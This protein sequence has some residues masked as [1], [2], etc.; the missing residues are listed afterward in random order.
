VARNERAVAFI[1]V[2]AL[3]LRS[4]GAWWR[5]PWHDEYFTAWAATLPFDRLIDALR[6]DS[7]PPLLYLMAR[8]LAVAG[9]PELAAARTVAV[10]AGTLAVVVAARAAGRAWG[11]AAAPGCA[12]LLAVHPVALAG[13]SGGRAYS[14]MLLAATLGWERLETLAATG[15]GAVGLG[16]AVALA[17]WSH[18]LG[19]IL[20][21]ALCLAA[22]LQP[23]ATRPRALLA[24]AAGLA[25]ILPWLPV[26]A[27]QPPAATV[28]MAASR[29][30]LPPAERLLAPIRLLPPAAPFDRALD[31]PGVAPAAALAAALACLILLVVVRPRPLPAALVGVPVVA[32]TVLPWLGV[33]V[34]YPGRAEAL[35]L[36]ALSG[37]VAAGAASWRPGRIVA[38][39][40]VAAGLAVWMGALVSWARKGPRPEARLAA[41][42]ASR[43]PEGGTVVLGGYWRLGLAFHLG[44]AAERYELINV[45][46]AA[47]RHRWYDPATDRPAPGEATGCCAVCTTGRRSR[48]SWCRVWL[49]EATCDDLAAALW[50]RPVLAV[51]AAERCAGGEWTRAVTTE[52]DGAGRLNPAG[53]VR[54]RGCRRPHGRGRRSSSRAGSARSVRALAFSAARHR[55]ARAPRRCGSAA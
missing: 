7:G 38:A 42:I 25:T 50:L 51:P 35:V 1:A 20:A 12:A 30:A 13:S 16:L 36:G 9:L 32:L 19:L 37:M 3:A 18:G 41:T 49:T 11:E 24:V 8:V 55:P 34:L 5:P 27:R 45:P 17:C 2:I 33:E 47:A 6:V 14:V 40:L 28:W 46:A 31:L 15:R 53:R 52:T 44:A 10:V 26:A 29:Q 22:L 23:R 4:L 39:L 21:G 48:S 54:H 43:M